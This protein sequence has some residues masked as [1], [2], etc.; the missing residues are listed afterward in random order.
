MNFLK[1]TVIV[2]FAG[3]VGTM[4]A[5]TYYA[6]ELPQ[7]HYDLVDIQIGKVG[8]PFILTGVDRKDRTDTVEIA[9]LVQEVTNEHLKKSAI[10]EAS[11]KAVY[12]PPNQLDSTH[13]IELSPKLQH[14]SDWARAESYLFGPSFENKDKKIEPDKTYSFDNGAVFIAGDALSKE[15]LALIQESFIVEGGFARNA[16]FLGD[17]IS[18]KAPVLREGAFQAISKKF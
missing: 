17:N 9:C 12:W 2:G 16:Y 1:K 6:D 5:A 10:D 14:G 15:K 11:N 7:P 13:M 3:M 8:E 4:G 18:E